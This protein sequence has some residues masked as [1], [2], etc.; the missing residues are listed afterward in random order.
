MHKDCGEVRVSSVKKDDAQIKVAMVM[1]DLRCLK[2]GEPMG[3]RSQ[4]VVTCVLMMWW[5][6]LSPSSSRGVVA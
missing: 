6:G 2:E 5:S 1:M 3:L 4:Q